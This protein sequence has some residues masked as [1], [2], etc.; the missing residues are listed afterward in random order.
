MIWGFVKVKASLRLQGCVFFHTASNGQA[1]LHK[2]AEPHFKLGCEPN[3][4]MVYLLADTKV[5]FSE[6]N[7]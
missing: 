7:A 4:T 1:S 5:A 3:G 2:H 6:E